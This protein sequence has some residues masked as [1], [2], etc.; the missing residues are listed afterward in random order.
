MRASYA[1]NEPVIVVTYICIL[2]IRQQPRGGALAAEHKPSS[3][4]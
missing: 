2:L 3:K 1:I 4:V